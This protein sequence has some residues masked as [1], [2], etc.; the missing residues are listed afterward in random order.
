MK[1]ISL[2]SNAEFLKNTFELTKDDYLHNSILRFKI[3]DYNGA[4][5]DCTNALKLDGKC[6]SA[7]LT[8]F[9]IRMELKDYSLAA[10]DF[11][12][13]VSLEKN[14]SELQKSTECYAVL[15]DIFIQMPKEE[16]IIFREEVRKKSNS[17]KKSK[18]LETN[19]YLSI[20][21]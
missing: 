6:L 9:I 20:V 19:S 15:F 7:F 2:Y 16:R 14:G 11:S 17:A 8:R 3:K 13:A 10:D 21:R 12:E 18:E 5:N 4:I 1:T